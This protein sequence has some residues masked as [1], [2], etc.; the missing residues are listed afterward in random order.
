MP[1]WGISDRIHG[2]RQNRL[3]RLVH[4]GGVMVGARLSSFFKSTR[5]AS[6]RSYR[7][8]ANDSLACVAPYQLMLGGLSTG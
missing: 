6:V 8:Q 7:N 1:C 4:F 2:R 5:T 3:E